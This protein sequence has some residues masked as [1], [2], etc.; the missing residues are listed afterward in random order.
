ME[1]LPISTT[2]HESPAPQ[3]QANANAAAAREFDALLFNALLSTFELVPS[4]GGRGAQN[5]I[6]AGMMKQALALELAQR[7]PLGAGAH[8]FDTTQGEEPK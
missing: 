7:H 3:A 5:D 1:I 6:Y 2:A 4:M 8:L